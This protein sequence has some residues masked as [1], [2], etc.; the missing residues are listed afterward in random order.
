MQAYPSDG[1]VGAMENVIA[2]DAYAP[3]VRRQLSDVCISHGIP[4]SAEPLASANASRVVEDVGHAEQLPPLTLSER[5]RATGIGM[6]SPG[7]A[8]P[9]VSKREM[10]TFAYQN[11]NP[12][13]C[14]M[15]MPVRM[16]S[17]TSNGLL[18]ETVSQPLR[19]E[20]WQPG[21]PVMGKFRPEDS[22]I[23]RFSEEKKNWSLPRR[24]ARQS[25]V[26][27]ASLA[28]GADSSGD[29]SGRNGFASTQSL[30][31]LSVAP[32]GIHSYFSANSTNGSPSAQ[33]T[34]ACDDDISSFVFDSLEGGT[35]SHNEVGA[36]DDVWRN[37][38]YQYIDIPLGRFLDEDDD[39]PSMLPVRVA[40]QTKNST[41]SSSSRR[42]RIR[43]GETR[44][45]VH[46]QL[47]ILIPSM[48]T[49]LCIDPSDSAQ[50]WTTVRLPDLPA[51]NCA[52]V[53]SK[54]DSRTK[55][56][57]GGWITQRLGI[58]NGKVQERKS[59]LRMQVVPEPLGETKQV[60]SKLLFSRERSDTVAL[61][62][63]GSGAQQSQGGPILHEIV[64]PRNVAE[65]GGLRSTHFLS[66]A[67]WLLE[68]MQG[69][70]YY[71]HVHT[72]ED[73]AD[74]SCTARHK[75]LDGTTMRLGPAA[76]HG[77]G[78][79]TSKA[80]P[81]ENARKDI[82]S[83]R[84][85][86]PVVSVWPL[87][88]EVAAH[89]PGSPKP[90]SLNAVGGDGSARTPPYLRSDPRGHS[91]RLVHMQSLAT[92]MQQVSSLPFDCSGEILN[93]QA[94]TEQ[95]VFAS[96]R[97]QP[98][99]DELRVDGA[100]RLPGN[101]GMLVAAFSPNSSSAE[102]DDDVDVQRER[103]TGIFEVLSL[104]SL[105][106]RQLSVPPLVTMARTSS[107]AHDK[108][109]GPV[110]AV[111]PIVDVAEMPV[112]SAA[113]GVT[114]IVTLQRS[115]VVR[116]W[117]VD[118]EGISRDRAVWR[119]MFGLPAEPTTQDEETT[120]AGQSVGKLKYDW[121]P[122]RSSIPRTGVSAPKHGK[123]DDQPHVGGNTWAGGTG[124][125]DTAGLGGRGGPCVFV[126]AARWSS[127]WR[128]GPVMFSAV[129]SFPQVPP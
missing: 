86:V 36:A 108:T 16:R 64:L 71:A 59:Q 3:H 52:P 109:A 74:T 93:M 7:A 32:M 114:D 119:E 47:A 29:D 98:L 14:T 38:T 99:P 15:T 89:E 22:R 20:R 9:S 8:R 43:P 65:A 72:P 21:S 76:A 12:N 6:R 62:D 57:V 97:A 1:V 5:W 91:S 104:D 82:S 90:A 128:A 63:L 102:D 50:A 18:C 121:G 116:Q 40:T 81:T 77:M 51:T 25:A 92:H 101:G 94:D 95:T 85:R 35:E 100:W 48:A 42:R 24:G 125:S 23:T 103:M 88:R 28:L 68:D 4:L 60:P 46:E 105:T 127:C 27:L 37:A 126:E 106:T 69:K 19:F 115:G 123:E 31:C 49:L 84:G 56:S 33:A 2:F 73:I 111:D 120:N 113:P 13:S 53:S 70:A 79:R 45:E 122:D 30:H 39:E 110:V 26:A 55:H 83:L 17:T 118:A 58:G 80:N 66:S 44:D 10:S 78:G 107:R 124:G 34:D 87:E 117:Q 129:D 61:L 41:A 54:K 112:A 67:L 75:G 11:N 96:R